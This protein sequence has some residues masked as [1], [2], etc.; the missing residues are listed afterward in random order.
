MKLE[1]NIATVPVVVDFTTLPE[2]SQAFV[3]EYG[4]R[5]Y[6]QDGA[7]VSKL[8][9]SGER[10]G[11]A[12]SE[13]E[14]A[15]EKAEGVRERLA[16]LQSGDFTRRGTAAPKMSPE[17][18]YRDQIV[19]DRLEKAVK[20]L[21]KRLPTKTGKN[22]DPE[23]LAKMKAAYYAKHKDS[24][25]KEVNRRLREDAKAEPEDLSDILG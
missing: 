6:I 19:T 2:A 17:E 12:K 1:T 18:R 3:I 21:G 5:Q 9:A 7:A 15:E 22:A 4:L 20:A 24:I 8:F 13:A 11:E 10:K 23:G 16:N 25:D 14:I